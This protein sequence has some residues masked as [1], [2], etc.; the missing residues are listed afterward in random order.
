MD[1]EQA[2]KLYDYLKFSYIP[3]PYQDKKTNIKWSEYQERRPTT[4][5]KTRWFKNNKDTNIAIVCG[6]ISD[7]LLVVDVDEAWIYSEVLADMYPD[8]LT[9]ETGK[10]YHLYFKTPMC[11][12]N[13]TFKNNLHVEF[14]GD[15]RYIVAPPSLHT[16]GSK[17]EF[18]EIREPMKVANPIKDIINAIKKYAPDVQHLVSNG[19]K[20]VPM[21]CPGVEQELTKANPNHDARFVIVAQMTKLGHTEEDIINFFRKMNYYDWDEDYT[22]YQIQ[23]IRGVG[24]KAPSCDNLRIHG[25]CVNCGYDKTK[26]D[27]DGKE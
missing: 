14:R 18:L 11:F 2:I 21:R 27:K 19:S 1:I 4:R 13:D 25:L 26:G 20:I 12:T 8:T 5:E 6:R 15:G 22:R 23:H 17:Y 3:V 7:N 24:Y 10:G 9:C 16:T